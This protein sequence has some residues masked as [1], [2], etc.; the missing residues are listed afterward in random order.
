MEA[1]LARCRPTLVLSTSFCACATAQRLLADPDVSLVLLRDSGETA[2]ILSFAWPWV[3]FEVCVSE[4]QLLY[5][6]VFLV[7]LF[8]AMNAPNGRLLKMNVPCSS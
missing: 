5:P 1:F 8:F 6:P 4:L 2:L 7:C 3:P